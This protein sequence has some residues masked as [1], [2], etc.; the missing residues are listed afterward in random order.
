MSRPKILSK[1]P[2]QKAHRGTNGIIEEIAAKE[3]ESIFN[4]EKDWNKWHDT[5][6]QGTPIEK[7][8]NKFKSLAHKVIDDALR[9]YNHKDLT[10]DGQ[11]YVQSRT[12]QLEEI[13]KLYDD[14]YRASE[15]AVEKIQ[16][17]NSQ[18]DGGNNSAE[19]YNVNTQLSVKKQWHTGLNKSQIKKV[20]DSISKAGVSGARQITDNTYWY[21][22]RLEGDGY[23]AIYSVS[24]S[25]PRPTIF[26]FQK[27]D[28][29]E[30]EL[31]ILIDLLE[32]EY[33]ESIDKQSS[34][35]QRVSS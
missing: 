35:T 11:I 8:W 1:T 16:S 6:G 28:D 19:S 7:A 9:V 32:E 27:G 4:S 31:D 25:S 30:T 33:G 2:R 17:K 13:K 15:K 21:K 23:F 26:Y 24:D 34:F 5:L 12:N 18:N 22:G 29:A 14:T 20:L 10:A 3:L